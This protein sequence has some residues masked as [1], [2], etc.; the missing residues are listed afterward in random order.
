MNPTHKT[1]T[2]KIRQAREAVKAGKIVFIDQSVIAADLLDLGCDIMDV[3]KILFELLDKVTPQDYAGSHP[4]Q[5]SYEEAITGLELYA[6]K[7]ESAA[8]GCIG[9]FKFAL[10]ENVLWLASLH[11]DRPIK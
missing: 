6:F 5:K 7:A 9:Y 8:L 11:E 2:G 4:P 10:Y 3:P 1:L